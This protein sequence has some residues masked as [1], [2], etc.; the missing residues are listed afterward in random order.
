MIRHG[1]HDAHDSSIKPSL[2]D[3]RQIPRIVGFKNPWLGDNIFP[4]CY[5]EAQEE[6]L[7]TARHGKSACLPKLD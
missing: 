6:F 1:S 5:F 7:G 3:E 2:R 4:R